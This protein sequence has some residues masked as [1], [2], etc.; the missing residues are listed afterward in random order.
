MIVMRCCSVGGITYAEFVRSI[1]RREDAVVGI[2]PDGRSLADPERVLGQIP[3]LRLFSSPLDRPSKPSLIVDP[4][5]RERGFRPYSTRNPRFVQA[6]QDVLTILRDLT[7]W[8]VTESCLSLPRLQSG[9]LGMRY[10]TG[11]RLTEL[12]QA[13]REELVFGRR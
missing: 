2:G 11:F 13:V 6:E 9:M 12:G 1:F 3:S 8:G 4:D 10:T 7:V 5:G